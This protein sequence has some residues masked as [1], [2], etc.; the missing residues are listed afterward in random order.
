M[1]RLVLK[2]DAAAGA[3]CL[4]DVSKIM[5]GLAPA[6]GLY[7]RPVDTPSTRFMI[8]RAADDFGI[9][10]MDT[11]PWY[12]CGKS[13]IDLGAALAERLNSKK[14]ADAIHIFTKVGRIAVPREIKGVEDSS[15]L[16]LKSELGSGLADAEFRRRHAFALQQDTCYALADET[17]DLVCI[18]DC[19]F[20]GIMTSFQ[21]S[22]ARLLGAPVFGIRL[23]DAD[24]EQL[25]AEAT[26]GSAEGRSGLDAMIE[27][28]RQ[29]LVQ[30]IGLGLNDAVV[31]LKYIR[32]ATSRQF[33]FDSI[34]IAGCWNLLN[35][36]GF[37]LLIECQACGIDVHL[38]GVFGAG[39]LHG[40]SKY[41]YAEA[42]SDLYVKREAWIKLCERHSVT[43][44]QLAL[45][46]AFRPQ[47]VSRVA[48]GC[49]NLSELESNVNLARESSPI[50]LTHLESILRDAVADPVI[51]FGRSVFDKMFP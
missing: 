24:S 44:Q 22:R 6:G 27:L 46:F 15:G 49:A 48:V 2:T 18:H 20:T 7:H 17:K 12:G 3:T 37:E 11:A 40:Q 1:S 33:K 25:F 47:C 5:L 50:A 14:E 31:A 42:G 36:S 45:A 34:M 28:R 10:E 19:T 13:E 21:Q 16:L 51:S 4:L 32:L 43:L 38:A 30:Q 26:I 41:L 23:H 39:F 9:R 29:G 8:Q 35:Q